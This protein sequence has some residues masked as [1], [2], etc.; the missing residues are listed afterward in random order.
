MKL[1][2]PCALL[3]LACGSTTAPTEHTPA[4]LV[5]ISVGA[6]HACGLTP[7]GAAYCWGYNGQ[8]QLGVGDTIT[9][10]SHAVAVS[11]G[12]TF[13]SVDVAYF[14]A[15][16]MTSAGPYCW[17]S[18]FYGQIGDS[19]TTTAPVPHLV[20]GGIV[21]AEVSGGFTSCGITL[22]GAPYCWGDNQQGELGNGDSVVRAPQL[23]PVRVADSLS[24]ASI[25]T[26]ILHTC[27]VTTA[28]DAYCWG[29]NAAGQL[30]SGTPALNQFT[31]GLVAGGHAFVTVSVGHEHTCGVTTSGS[32]YCWGRNNHGQLGV[33][34]T[35]D[36]VTPVLVNGSLTF[37]V[38][39]TGNEASCG[40]TVGGAAFCWGWNASGG[41]GD[42]TTFDRY[43]PS[44][45]EGPTVFTDIS[46]GDSFAC[47]VTQARTAYCWGANTYGQL[48]NGSTTNS[49][50]P[51]QVVY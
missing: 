25:S 18:N 24:F 43:N 27:G 23:T 30:G 39:R 17:G 9:N 32:A 12:L 14:D 4:T 3:A 6:L 38:V 13:T 40:V 34:D 48:G 22:L 41:L 44:P 29:L 10:R 49:L 50:V 11:G 19:T 20:R 36:R 37:R 31:P 42:G 35:L 51:V 2:P 7:T 28:G 16:G 47:G 33:G 46:V 26:A 1:A 8:G 5:A 45:V 21:F 15:C